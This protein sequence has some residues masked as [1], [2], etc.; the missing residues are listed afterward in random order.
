MP[1][2]T[3][4][5]GDSGLGYFWACKT[6][7]AKEVFSYMSFLGCFLLKGVV[8]GV[9]EAFLRIETS[10]SKPWKAFL[11]EKAIDLIGYK[12]VKGRCGF[13]WVEKNPTSTAALWMGSL[14]KP[15]LIDKDLRSARQKVPKPKTR[16]RKNKRTGRNQK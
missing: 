12:G 14:K 3:D 11:F 15:C 6:F 13:L 2:A 10:H 1:S 8:R 9:F 16:L 5:F 7:R 4:R